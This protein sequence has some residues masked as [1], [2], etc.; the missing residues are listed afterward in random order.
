M[1][2]LQ[3]HLE[4]RPGTDNAPGEFGVRATFRNASQEPALLNVHQAAHPSL[5]LEVRDERDQPGLPPSEKRAW[6]SIVWNWLRDIWHWI[7]C[8]IKRI[9]RRSPRCDRVLTVE[10]DEARTETISNAPAGSESWNGTYGW[11]A[12]FHVTVD[13]AN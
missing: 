6:Y 7:V 4:A 9:F 1:P 3:V 12:R 2:P 11:H 13:E 5:V 8:L 10:M